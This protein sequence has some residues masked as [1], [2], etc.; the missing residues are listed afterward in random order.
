MLQ[1]VEEPSLCYIR[2]ILKGGKNSKND[3]GK[4]EALV[5]LSSREAKLSLQLTLRGDEEARGT[6]GSWVAFKIR[7]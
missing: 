2:Q 5:R 6:S 4:E 7:D 3:E 1:K